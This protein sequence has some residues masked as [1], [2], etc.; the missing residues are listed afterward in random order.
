MFFL[1]EVE[2]ENYFTGQI[3]SKLGAMFVLAEWRV[4]NTLI[5]AK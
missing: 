1:D 4:S 3:N 2:K 5:A